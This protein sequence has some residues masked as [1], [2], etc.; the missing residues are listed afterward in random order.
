MCDRSACY[1]LHVEADQDMYIFVK[2]LAIGI[3]KAAADFT[4]QQCSAF[5]I[6]IYI[7][8]LQVVF[9]AIWI[10]TVLYVFSSAQAKN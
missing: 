8:I 3:M 7:T 6:P 9:L 2:Y 1:L 5:L 4:R 10:T